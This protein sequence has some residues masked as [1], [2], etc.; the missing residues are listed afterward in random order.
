M[1]SQHVTLMNEEIE[2]VFIIL[3]LLAL[4]NFGLLGLAVLIGVLY[5]YKSS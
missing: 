2:Y 3:G 4:M 1:L 5:L